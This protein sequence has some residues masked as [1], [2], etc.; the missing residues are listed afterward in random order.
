MCTRVGSVL[1]GVFVCSGCV[2][3]GREHPVGTSWLSVASV[4]VSCY[5]ERGVS[6]CT[7][8]TLSC[9]TPC[10][11]PVQ[12]AGACC[13]LCPCKY[14]TCHEYDLLSENWFTYF[15]RVCQWDFCVYA[16]VAA[17]NNYNNNNNNNF[18][19]NKNRSMQYN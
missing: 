17:C 2:Y 4:C 8:L 15:T 18:Y 16:L 6:L 12:L 9:L 7:D 13:P 19:S 5:C 14:S 3:E 11:H 10:S 1:T